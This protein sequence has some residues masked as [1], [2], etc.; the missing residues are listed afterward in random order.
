MPDVF[1]LHSTYSGHDNSIFAAGSPWLEEAIIP[2]LMIQIGGRSCALDMY[3]M[4]A[5][6]DIFKPTIPPVVGKGMEMAS[7][8]EESWQK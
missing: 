2:G 8:L 4:S 6:E 3:V 1:P 7:Y 5:E